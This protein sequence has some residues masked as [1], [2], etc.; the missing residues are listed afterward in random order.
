[1][2]GLAHIPAR[3]TLKPGVLTKKKKR[4]TNL[5]KST[6]I[7]TLIASAAICLSLSACSVTPVTHDRQT[8]AY[9]GNDQTAG[10]LGFNEVGGLTISPGGRERY[11][12]LIER[13]GRD[14]Q[15]E[16]KKDFGITPREDGNYDLTA[17]GAERWKKMKIIEDRQRINDSDKLINL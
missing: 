3:K 6:R 16:T 17:E 13:F 8:I 7:K 5:M 9:D 4:K 15:P 14:T 11:D 1:M 12:S 2:D 10:I